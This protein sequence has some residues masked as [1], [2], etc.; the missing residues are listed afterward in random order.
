MHGRHMVV[1]GQQ[2]LADGIAQ[3]HPH[4]AAQ[5]DVEA[6]PHPLRAPLADHDHPLEGAGLGLLVA[7]CDGVSRHVGG[8]DDRGGGDALGDGGAGQLQRRAVGRGERDDGLEAAALRGR[9]HRDHPWLVVVDGARPRTLVAARRG[10][11]DPGGVGVEEGDRHGIG[12]RV[13]AAADREVDDVHAVEHRLADR[14]HGVGREAP[15][16]AARLVDGDVGPWRDPGD[17][18]PVPPEQRGGADDAPGRRRRRVRAV[19][20]VVACAVGVGVV[21]DEVVHV[22]ERLAG[23]ELVLALERPV[24]TG[25][26]RVGPELAGALRLVGARRRG[27]DRAVVDERRVLGPGA[28]VEHPDD[29]APTGARPTAELVPHGRGADEA[30]AGVGRQGAEVVGLHGDHAVHLDKALRLVR[31]QA[32]H[33]ASVHRPQPVRDDGAGRQRRQLGLEPGFERG[34]VLQVGLRRV[35]LHREVG[36]RHRRAR[37]LQAG[38]VPPVGRQRVVVELH[39]HG[40]HASG[41]RREE[42]PIAAGHGAALAP[43]RARDLALDRLERAT[44]AALRRRPVRRLQRLDRRGEQGGEAG[45]SGEAGETER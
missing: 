18:A 30:G 7:Q 45:Q 40:D 16:R 9:P 21:V 23:D 17:L 42:V 43:P 5:R 14:G 13:L 3:Q 24:G 26:G 27:R 35:A 32:H 4:P 25:I 19:P 37:R 31:G 39:E 38:D 12:Q 44:P 15:L 8:D 33:E 22:E 29:H 34:D 28:G 2:V 36:T 20:D 11:Q 6:L 41:L 10:D 1:V